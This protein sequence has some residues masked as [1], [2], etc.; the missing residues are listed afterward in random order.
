LINFLLAGRLFIDFVSA[1]ALEGSRVYTGTKS[2][3]T[4]N[5]FGG[6]EK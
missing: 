2:D 1:Y 3:N 5:L 4:K 6:I